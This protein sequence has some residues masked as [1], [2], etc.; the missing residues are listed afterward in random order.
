MIVRPTCVL[1]LSDVL[2]DPDNPWFRDASVPVMRDLAERSEVFPLRWRG[3]E[4]ELLG[5]APGSVQLDEGPLTV[6]SMGA[7]PPARSVHFR[8]TPLGLVDGCPRRPRPEPTAEELARIASLAKK[9]DTPSLRFLAEGDLMALVWERGSLDLATTP[10][11]ELADR[12]LKA[13]LPEGDGEPTLRRFI[14]DG[15]NLLHEEEFNLRRIDEGHDPVDVLWPWGQGFRA[16]LPNLPLAR[17]KTASFA[18]NSVRLEGISRLARYRHHD[19]ATFGRGTALQLEALSTWSLKQETSVIWIREPGAFRREG[20]DEMRGEYEWLL[21]ELDSR[22]LRPL[23]EREEPPLLAILAP[24]N[25][26]LGFIF[27]PEKPA[28]AKLPFDERALEESM[29]ARELSDVMRELLS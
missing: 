4:T 27:D 2:A 3:T 7:D 23:A 13:V 26:G 25:P 17:G 19:R 5:L 6:A 22:F 24:G 21:R 10:P 28:I 20:T 11:H 12:P 29:P 8:V 16:E 1:I 15:I 14:D 18:S 9:L